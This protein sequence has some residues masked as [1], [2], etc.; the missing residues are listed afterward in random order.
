MKCPQCHREIPDDA[1]G[2]IHCWQDVQKPQQPLASSPKAAQIETALDKLDIPHGIS[3]PANAKTLLSL[4][5]A[6]FKKIHTHSCT[7]WY[8]GELCYIA[9]VVSAAFLLYY[10]VSQLLHEPSLSSIPLLTYVLLLFVVFSL[11][12][13]ASAGYLLRHIRTRAAQIIIR[14]LSIIAILFAS[15]FLFNLTFILSLPL[16]IGYVHVLQA[17]ED[18][19]LFS[20]NPLSHRQIRYFWQQIKEQKPIEENEIPPERTPG[21]HDK[22][23]TILSAYCIALPFILA[24]LLLIPALSAA[25]EASRSIACQSNLKT[26]G[27]NL[28]RYQNEHSAYPQSIDEIQTNPPLTCPCAKKRIPY[29]FAPGFPPEDSSLELA[30][31]PVIVCSLHKRTLLTLFGDGH[32]FGE[33]KPQN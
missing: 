28:Q 16:I 14:V 26:L 29:M 18:K 19:H 21:R 32:V 8:C 27:Q 2:C 20:T 5:L 23:H 24:A 22:L 7:L 13:I 1:K 17:S 10:L 33:S 30:K 31:V 9:A 6:E 3:L 4:P 11:A 15:P 12:S 25:R